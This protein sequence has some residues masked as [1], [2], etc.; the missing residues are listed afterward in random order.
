MKI[1]GIE[2]HPTALVHKKAE[3][4]RGVRIGPYSVIGPHVRIGK[5][6]RIHNFVV[7]DGRTTVGERNEIF[8]GV[9]IGTPPQVLDYKDVTRSGV[10][11]G[12]DNVIREYATI[13]AAMTDGR[14]T[15]VG[16]KNFIMI[17][18][19][20]GHDCVIGSEVT[21]ANAVALSGHVQVEDH[22]TIG[23]LVGVHQF[24]RVGKYSMIGGVS[25]VVMDIP[26]FSLCSGYPARLHGLNA[27]G[28]RR[29][30]Y[31]PKE[32][33]RIKKALRMLFFSK[34]HRAE[35]IAKVRAEFDHNADVKHLLAFIEHS[36]RG[37]CRVTADSESND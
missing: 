9:C 4:A 19:H 20:I 10:L 35:A 16:N 29:A 1:P 7:I 13:S 17:T 28:L 25:R 24:A 32:A 26:P 12:D 8:S 5:D 36:K 37:V 21:M 23:G 34:N 27:V 14:S 18:A 33:M 31:S 22:A 3:L 2:I 6:T 15:V 30:G 11:I